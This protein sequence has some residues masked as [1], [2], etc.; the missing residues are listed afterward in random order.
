MLKA[1][2]DPVDVGL[3]SAQGAGFV[4]HYPVSALPRF[5]AGLAGPGGQ[6]EARFSFQAVQG[7]PALDGAV[8]TQVQA[9]CQ[10]CLE[11]FL[12][13]LSAELHIAFTG[14]DED[15][16][17]VPAPYE[18]LVLGDTRVVLRDLVEDEL[19]LTFPLVPMHV[20]GSPA[21]Q[22]AVPVLAE[23]EVLAAVLEAEDAPVAAAA[24]QDKPAA[25]G[26]THPFAGLKDLMRRGD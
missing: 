9:T 14:E 19:L 8:A 18:A 17:Q 11:P 16:A 25:E 15:E 26:T 7:F 5:A 21:C 20:A 4:C 6:V 22:P 3:L 10:R 13:D 23:E 1:P 12:L 2:A 24:P